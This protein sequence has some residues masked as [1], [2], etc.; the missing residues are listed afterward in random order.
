MKD[1]SEEKFSSLRDAMVRD[2]LATRGISDI[3]V[4][5]AMSKVPRHR[6]V[7]PHLVAEA[8]DDKAIALGPDQSISQPFIVGLML[9]ELGVSRYQRVLEIGTGSG[10]QTALLAEMAESVYSVELDERLSKESSKILS[11]LGYR[12]IRLRVGDGYEGWPEA[13][14]FDAVIVS[15]AP[16][17]LPR[18]LVKQLVTGGTMLLPIGEEDDQ[19]LVRIQKTEEGLSHFDLGTVRF[20]KMKHKSDKEW[21]C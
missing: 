19:C 1:H 8:Y 20:V 2:Q 11:E 12:N 16:T 15:A 18:T 3:N 4:L 7:P 10:Y 14:P 5:A 13:A 17:E 21:Y 6:F 9:Q